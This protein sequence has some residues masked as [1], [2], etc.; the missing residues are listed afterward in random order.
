MERVIWNAVQAVLFVLM[1]PFY[2]LFWLL[3]RLE[4]QR[5]PGC[6]SKWQTELMGEW[7][8]EDWHCHACGRWWQYPEKPE[9]KVLYGDD[10]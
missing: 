4:A 8:G 9:D 2:P 1:L 6:G 3:C 10:R 7:D 5:C